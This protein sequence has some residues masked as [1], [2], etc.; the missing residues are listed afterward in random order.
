MY[1][2]NINNRLIEKFYAHFMCNL[3]AYLKLTFANLNLT[4]AWLAN[5]TTTTTTRNIYYK[6]LFTTSI[7]MKQANKGCHYYYYFFEFYLKNL[8]QQRKLQLVSSNL[9]GFRFK[10]ASASASASTL[11]SD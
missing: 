6:T 7:I 3:R 5:T 11:E 8:S 9:L 1:L 10:L 2:T 4:S